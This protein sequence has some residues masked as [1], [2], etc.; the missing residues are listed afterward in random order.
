MGTVGCLAQ[1]PAEVSGNAV[2]EWGFWTGGFAVWYSNRDWPCRRGGAEV[3]IRGS[4]LLNG[5]VSSE[6]NPPSSH[7]EAVSFRSREEKQMGHRSTQHAD[8]HSPAFNVA[9][10]LYLHVA[11]CPQVHSLGTSPSRRQPSA[12]LLPRWRRGRF[13][14]VWAGGRELGV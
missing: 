11:R 3:S 10:C 12:S 5:P 6:N 2:G 1:G 4:L 14:A 7:L 9:P 13:R 8:S